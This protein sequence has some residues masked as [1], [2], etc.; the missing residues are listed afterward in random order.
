MVLSIIANPAV[1]NIPGA[2]AQG[3][4]RG[5]DMQEMRRQNALA[6]LMQEQGPA[7][8]AGDKNALAQ[9]AQV[10]PR[11]AMDFQ[12][13]HLGMDATRLGMDSTR[14]SMAISAEQLQMARERA[15]LQAEQHARGISREEAAAESAKIE[16]VLQG[17]MAAQDE[18]SY[19]AW[20]AQN[21]VD[22]AQFSFA[23]RELHFASAL[24]VKDYMDVKA[25]E[26]AMAAGPPPADEYGRYVQEEMA[27]GREPLSRIDYAQAKKG[28]E[29]IYGPDGQ[30]II[31]RGPGS[32]KPL[33]ES[34]SKDTVYATRAEGA[35]EIFEPV[36]HHLTSRKN[37]I[38]DKVPMGVG[39]D[40]QGSEYQIAAA[41]G[42]EFL[43]AI[44]RKDT[45]AAITD[46]EQVLYGSVYLPQPGD[47]DETLEYRR[48]ARARA[49]AA[50]KAGMPP[51]AIL[52]QEKALAKSRSESGSGG[53]Q[54][55]SSG[56]DFG[57][58]GVMDIES[59]VKDR[60]RY[61]SLTPEQK[62]A[63]RSRLQTLAG[64]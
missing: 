34:Q 37:K 36:S 50:L 43:Q 7:I 2:Y 47:D 14:Q 33:T 53:G 56:L 26:A 59:L 5:H 39:R 58:M 12:K 13:Q 63:L 41:A 4:Q 16:R 6:Q 18:A 46:S 44:L 48:N 9:L 11:A 1:A 25:K 27:A 60:A 15:R 61:D 3:M 10:D 22:P 17:A 40:L 57:S 23:E 20:L 24:G 64:Q 51:Q 55:P 54:N 8:L 32:M 38:L 21:G 28:T 19:N 30:P 52:A 49:V 31:Q 45:G 42:Q 62:S 29:I 35:L